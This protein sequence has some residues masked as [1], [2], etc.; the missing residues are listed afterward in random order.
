MFI[1]KSVFAIW[2]TCAYS[3]I[4]SHRQKKCL[5]LYENGEQWI[6][7]PAAC[8]RI[9][10]RTI[11]GLYKLYKHLIKQKGKRFLGMQMLIT[12]RRCVGWSSLFAM[13]C[14]TFL[15]TCF[16]YYLMEQKHAQ[17]NHIHLLP[18]YTLN[19]ILKYLMNKIL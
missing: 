11:Y 7:R 1:R 16:N 17:Y 13:I 14:D 6:F 19:F 2:Y 4:E 12:L 15:T 3:V 8:W 9:L 10:L 18:L 5:M